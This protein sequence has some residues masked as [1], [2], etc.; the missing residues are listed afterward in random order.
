MV[1][2]QFCKLGVGGSTPSTG[3]F[4]YNNPYIPPKRPKSMAKTKQIQ[5]SKPFPIES[6]KQARLQREFLKIAYKQGMF[7]YLAYQKKIGGKKV[8]HRINSISKLE[9]IFGVL[10]TIPEGNVYVAKI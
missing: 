5:Y 4:H 3:F 2:H 8:E 7:N 1:E 6:K 9:E 10:I